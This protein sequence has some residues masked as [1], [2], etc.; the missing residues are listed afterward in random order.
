MTSPAS[1]RTAE[2][3]VFD[4]SPARSRRG[5]SEKKYAEASTGEMAPRSVTRSLVRGHESPTE[6]LTR[7]TWPFV[8][9]RAARTGPG[10]QVGACQFPIDWNDVAKYALRYPI[11]LRPSLLCTVRLE[12]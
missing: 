3:R 11:A 5:T 6:V 12:K 9:V 8:T 10:T 4:L 7:V 1:A 2:R